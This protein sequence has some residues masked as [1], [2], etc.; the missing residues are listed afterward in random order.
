[1]FIDKRQKNY[2]LKVLFL[3]GDNCKVIKLRLMNLRMTDNFLFQLMVSL[4]FTCTHSCFEQGSI[5]RE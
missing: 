5:N 4:V 1:M 2:C 3:H